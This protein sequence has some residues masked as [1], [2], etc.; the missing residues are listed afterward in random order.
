MVVQYTVDNEIMKVCHI[1]FCVARSD[2]S[3]LFL[4][5]MYTECVCGWVVQ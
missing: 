1:L 2:C 4:L 5:L 3:Q